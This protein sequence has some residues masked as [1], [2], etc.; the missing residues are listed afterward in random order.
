LNEGCGADGPGQ[1]SSATPNAWTA[2][3]SRRWASRVL[4]LCEL[5]ASAF[6]RPAF[7]L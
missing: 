3:H 5:C 4:F 6:N 7:V 1:R 2:I